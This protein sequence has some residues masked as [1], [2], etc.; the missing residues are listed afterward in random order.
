MYIWMA[1]PL[2][3][4]L[5]AALPLF[6]KDALAFWLSVGG[7]GILSAWTVWQLTRKTT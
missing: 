1:V 6:W 7:T 4:L 3:T 5:L 2:V